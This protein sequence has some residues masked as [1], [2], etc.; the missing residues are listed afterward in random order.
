[1]SKVSPPAYIRP[2]GSCDAAA[3]EGGV[4][5]GGEINEASDEGTGC[6]YDLGGKLEEASELLEFEEGAARL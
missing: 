4:E 5:C 6:R 1:M 2:S 3:R